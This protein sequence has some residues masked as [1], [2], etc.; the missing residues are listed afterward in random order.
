[1][2]EYLEYLDLLDF[3]CSE[4]AYEDRWSEGS[5]SSLPHYSPTMFEDCE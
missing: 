5:R 4:R 2:T 1:M 3:E